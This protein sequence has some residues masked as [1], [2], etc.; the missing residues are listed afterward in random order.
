[1]CIS[2]INEN[3]TTEIIKIII[4]LVTAANIMANVTSAADKG[5]IKVSIILPWILAIINDETECENPCWLIEMAISP[6]ARKLIKEKPNTLPRS[7]PKASVSTDK[8]S[9]LDTHISQKKLGKEI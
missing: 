6:G 9:K 5:A 4:L 1:M 2:I 8:N 7:L 3:T